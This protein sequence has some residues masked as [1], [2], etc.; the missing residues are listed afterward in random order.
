MFT[1]RATAAEMAKYGRVKVVIVDNRSISGLLK[2]NLAA[3][4]AGNRLGR[5]NAKKVSNIKAGMFRNV[6]MNAV[7]SR[8]SQVRRLRRAIAPVTPTKSDD[9]VVRIVSTTV[10]ATPVSYTHLTLPT[11]PYV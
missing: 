9:T 3:Q 6:S 5:A 8:R 7:A 1:V 4:S 11:T 10:T 2:S